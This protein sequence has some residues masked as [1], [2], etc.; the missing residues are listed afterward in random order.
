MEVIDLSSSDD[1]DD[2][3]GLKCQPKEKNISATEICKP[4]NIKDGSEANC[5]GSANIL[6]DREQIIRKEL[7]KIR[8]IPPHLALVQTFYEHQW[9]KQEDKTELPLSE[10]K[11]GIESPK[12]HIRSA[13]FRSLW[14]RGFHITAGEKFGADFL[15]YQ[16]R[17]LHLYI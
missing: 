16:G 14:S 10:W 9:L 17:N 4:G 11:Y 5:E 3:E 8:D 7:S 13:T 6:I 15:A 1:N 2:S 12:E